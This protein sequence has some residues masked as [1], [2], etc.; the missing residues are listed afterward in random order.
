MHDLT[1]NRFLLDVDA[2]LFD[3]LSG[4]LGSATFGAPNRVEQRD[5]GLVGRDLLAG[6]ISRK[7]RSGRR[8]RANRTPS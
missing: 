7:T 2:T 4:I 3:K 5:V 8:E 6:R 1:R